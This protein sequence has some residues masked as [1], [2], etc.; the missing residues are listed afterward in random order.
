D[1]EPHAHVVPK[2]LTEALDREP[3]AFRTKEFLG[4]IVI[5]W[6]RR[7]ELE[8]EGQPKLTVAREDTERWWYEGDLRTYADEEH[9]DKLLTGL[10]DLRATRFITEGEPLEQAQASLKT[11][12]QV[13]RVRIVPDVKRED[14]EPRLVELRVGGACPGQAEERVAQAGSQ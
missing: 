1:D 8:G 5:G 13:V 2:T 4:N 14:Q 9:I 7:I 10:D 11:P 6:A 3:W 12:A